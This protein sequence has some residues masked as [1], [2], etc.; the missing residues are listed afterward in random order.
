[1]S[2]SDIYGFLAN[3]SVINP[4]LEEMRKGRWEQDEQQTFFNEIPYF[5]QRTLST[6][7]LV[8]EGY[9]PPLLVSTMVAAVKAINSIKEKHNIKF[10]GFDATAESI[11]WR[12]FRDDGKDI[13]QTNGLTIDTS[14]Q[15]S[16]PVWIDYIGTYGS[17]SITLSDYHAVVIN[18][19]VVG[20]ANAEKISGYKFWSANLTEFPKFFPKAVVD[21]AKEFGVLFFPSVKVYKIKESLGLQLRVDVKENLGYIVPNGIVVGHA[22]KY[23][24]NDP[25]S[26]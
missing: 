13:D 19:L 20:Q 15:A 23:L 9:L 5:F 25:P 10:R 6:R 7:D 22:E 17:S 2:V 24:N 16:V 14:G 21:Q 12:P 4:V 8:L 26:W 11:G 1:M 3:Q 18:G